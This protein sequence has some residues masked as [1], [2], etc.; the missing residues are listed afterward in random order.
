MPVS[1]ELNNRNRGDSEQEMNK[2]VI[3]SNKIL[4]MLNNNDYNYFL[5]GLKIY[6]KSGLHV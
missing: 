2:Q 3:K 6:K 1:L 5:S 4:F